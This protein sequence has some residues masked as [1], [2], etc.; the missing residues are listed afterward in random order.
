MKDKIQEI[1]A[2]YA[3]KCSGRELSPVFTNSYT[4]GLNSSGLP[5]VSFASNLHL[6]TVVSYDS[7]MFEML[8]NLAVGN[9]S[10]QNLYPQKD[11]VN[12]I[13]D[14]SSNLFSLRL[15]RTISSLVD[16]LYD[17][18]IYDLDVKPKTSKIR[19][20]FFIHFLREILP[21]LLCLGN[22]PVIHKDSIVWLNKAKKK[23]PRIS[24]EETTFLDHLLF[25]FQKLFKMGVDSLDN[26]E[27]KIQWKE[28]HI[29][30]NFNSITTRGV[31][32]LEFKDIS[33]SKKNVNDLPIHF[34]EFVEDMIYNRKSET[35]NSVLSKNG[36]LKDIS[37]STQ[38]QINTSEK[39][40]ESMEVTTTQ[41]T[42]ENQL[43]NSAVIT[44][45][46]Q[47]S[48][49]KSSRKRTSASSKED[50]NYMMIEGIYSGSKKFKQL[51][52]DIQD[53]ERIP[54]DVKSKID[55]A[56]GAFDNLFNTIHKL[57]KC[58]GSENGKESVQNESEDDH[59]ISL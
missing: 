29:K 16:I 10:K 15:S 19:Q 18:L 28:K 39:N 52:S 55:S 11:D 17:H 57:Y 3:K 23:M 49:T 56:N 14:Y 9:F 22:H 7:V 53:S 30:G 21:V 40:P 1:K 46:S 48:K 37:D 45:E 50:P 44:T 36:G 24:V 26:S 2:Y 54:D 4:Q 5:S 38:A 31:I 25:S 8:Q 27:L 34:K 33:Y 20:M 59:T 35:Y 51:M 13:I 41:P 32:N 43:E 6:L 58:M 47:T 42:K 12:K